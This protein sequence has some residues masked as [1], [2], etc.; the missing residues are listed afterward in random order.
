MDAQGHPVFAQLLEQCPDLVERLYGKGA[1]GL[2]K[3]FELL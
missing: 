2:K 3:D 1:G